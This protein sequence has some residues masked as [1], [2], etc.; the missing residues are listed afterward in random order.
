MTDELEYILNVLESVDLEDGSRWECYSTS[1][2]KSTMKRR[3]FLKGFLA[4][5][6]TLAVAPVLVLEPIKE[7]VVRSCIV[8]ELL[9]YGVYSDG[10]SMFMAINKSEIVDLNNNGAKCSIPDILMLVGSVCTVNFKP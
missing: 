4:A 7:P 10:K 3:N 1:G 2:K 5:T 8:G 6:G 9:P